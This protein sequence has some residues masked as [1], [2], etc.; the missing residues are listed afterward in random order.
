MLPIEYTKIVKI[1][2]VKIVQKLQMFFGQIDIIAPENAVRREGE[3]C[4]QRNKLVQ[5]AA[6]YARWKQDELENP[7]NILYSY[8][9]R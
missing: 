3:N 5:K 6:G 4:R 9:I 7:G 8:F 2:R 1:T